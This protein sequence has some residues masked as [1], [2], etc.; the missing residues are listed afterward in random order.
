MVNIESIDVWVLK[1]NTSG[2]RIAEACIK[3]NVAAV[4]WSINENDKLNEK[5]YSF[6]DYVNKASLLHD[7]LSKV[8]ALVK[9]IK[10]NDLIWI[11]NPNEGYYYIG[12]RIDTSMWQYSMDLDDYKL[13]MQNQL[14]NIVWH[15]IGD[16]SD[17]PGVITSQFH[18]RG[19]TLYR[20]NTGWESAVRYSSKIYNEVS[21]ENIYD[22][23][24]I[25]Y[26]KDNFFNMLS[27]D[28]VED[29]IY[30]YLYDKYGYIVVPSSNKIGT[31]NYE[32]VLLDKNNPEKRVYVQ[33]KNGNID[34]V[35]DDYTE[36]ANNQN[37]FYLFT[38][39][40]VKGKNNKNIIR[41]TEQELFDWLQGEDIIVSEAIRKWLRFISNEEIGTKVKGIM[42]DT[43]KTYYEKDEM[44]MLKQSK[45]WAKGNP[46]RYIKSFNVDDYVLY[47]SKGDGIVAIGKIVDN[48][49]EDIEEDGLARKVDILVPE[50]KYL[51][52]ISQQECLYPYEIKSLLKK[53][54]YF[55]STIKSPYLN[56]EEVDIL[57]DA[58]EKKYREKAK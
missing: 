25:K 49:I 12:R 52:D 57:K 13:D 14:T 55:A 26:D 6:E 28:E 43:N 37:E 40:D 54:F 31:P 11:R 22:C 38:R 42:F 41:I 53:N 27:P 33:A 2:G 29:L 50:K 39:G 35:T 47:Y 51:D 56:K 23:Q 4:G 9:K 10:V 8:I 3:K 1:T 32:Y 21:K 48:E 58:L 30:F 5:V 45:V 24:A 19:Q 17:V 16:E 34:L 46:K 44:E 7:D 15:R 36:L 20:I 18:R